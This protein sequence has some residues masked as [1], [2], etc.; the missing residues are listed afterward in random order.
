[1]RQFISYSQTSR[2]LMIQLKV[3]YNI[4]IEFGV[5]MK[6]DRLLKYVQM[7]CIVKSM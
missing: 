4:L 1:M 2:K 3:L 7:K 5:L 6:L